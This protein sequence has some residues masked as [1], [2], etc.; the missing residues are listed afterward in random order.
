M[1]G[2]LLIYQ[3][4]SLHLLESFTLFALFEV[5]FFWK[6]L[7]CYNG[8]CSARY[9]SSRQRKGHYIVNFGSVITVRFC[10]MG[11]FFFLDQS[12]Y[13]SSLY[14]HCET[15]GRTM[16]VVNLDPAAEIFN[17]PVAMGELFNQNP[18]GLSWFHTF[19]VFAVLQISENLFLWKM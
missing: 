15:V 19:L 8:L 11:I 3:S 7:L 5:F 6:I 2:A 1:F 13:C 18:L 17:Y 16:N 4:P 9:R 10:L 12:T 14:E